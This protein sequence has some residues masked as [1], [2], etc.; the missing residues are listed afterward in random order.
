MKRRHWGQLAGVVLLAAALVIISVVVGVPGVSRLRSDFAQ[1]GIWA[2]VI[3]AGLFALVS[4][5]PL[6]ASVFTLA[7]GALFGVG[8]GLVVVEI[9]ATAGAVIAFYL[10]R[11]LG[12]DFVARVSG[13]SVERFDERFARRGFAAVL[14]VRLVPVIPFAAVNYVSGLTSVRFLDYLG[15]TVLGIVPASAA[16]AALG[17]Y[18]SKPGS[19][20]FVAA[21]GGLLVLLVVGVAGGR[22]SRRDRGI[23]AAIVATGPPAVRPPC[24]ADE[25]GPA[26][27]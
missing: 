24:A 27:G 14:A 17:A 16:Y 3:Y 15:G 1:F 4:L 5:A 11:V 9:G 6:P 25:D 23:V 10:A 18:G 7:A 13:A 8:D 20:P 19:W 21:L 12:R 2:G 26:P 22:R